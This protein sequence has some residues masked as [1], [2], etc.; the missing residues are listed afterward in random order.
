[1]T[2]HTI[3]ERG[4]EVWA[5]SEAEYKKGSFHRP[6][7]L[8]AVILPDGEETYY[9]HGL[10]HRENGPAKVT[11]KKHPYENVNTRYTEWWTCGHLIRVCHYG[12][13]LTVEDY[14]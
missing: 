4:A 11:F 8:P 2:F 3:T 9:E 1:V 6:N 13:I 10:L 12:S 5:K 14:I 7:G